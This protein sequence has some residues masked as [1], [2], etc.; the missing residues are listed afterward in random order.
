LTGLLFWIKTFDDPML[1]FFKAAK[2]DVLSHWYALI[3]GFKTS[4]NEFYQSIEQ[5]LKSRQVPGLEMSRIEF[6]EGGLLSDKREYLRMS[7]ER[8]VLDVCAAP[9]GTA[10]FFSCR[11]A[12]IPATIRLWQLFVLLIVFGVSA[13]FSLAICTR[14]F[15]AL[16]IF[17]WPIGWIFFIAFLIYL[18]RN[19]VTMGLRDLD[20]F[21]IKSPLGPIYERW[22]RRETYYRQD[23]RLMYCDTVNAVVKGLVEEITAAKG[24]KLVQFNEYNPILGELYKPAPPKPEPK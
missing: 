9:F 14:V 4:T 23:T 8:L 11:F 1:S 19:A 15:G 22:F 10:Y 13:L 5:E 12:E 20:A 24:V 2:A 17:I 7:R 3:P 6:S 16:T 21:L 18:L